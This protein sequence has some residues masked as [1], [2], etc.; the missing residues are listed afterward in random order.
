VNRRENLLGG[1]VL[2]QPLAKYAKEICLFNIL[3]TIEDAAGH[4]CKTLEG[5]ICPAEIGNAKAAQT[6]NTHSF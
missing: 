2:E 3:F 4:E 1:N 6:G 5:A